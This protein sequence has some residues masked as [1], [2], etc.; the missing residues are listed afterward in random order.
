[1]LQNPGESETPPGRAPAWRAS[2]LGGLA[3]LAAAWLVT[4][5][6]V[7]EASATFE[8]GPNDHCCLSGFADHYEVEDG[9]GTRWTSYDATLDLPLVVE[10]GPVE[11]EL[12]GARVFPQTA[13]VELELAGATVDRGLVEGGVLEA[14]R[15]VA[16]GDVEAHPDPRAAGMAGD[17]GRE[18]VW[19][20]PSATGRYSI[21]AENRRKDC[22]HC[23][24]GWRSGRHCN[25]S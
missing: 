24:S 25:R 15:R 11:L 1:M 17:A 23:F 12:R 2:L 10:G 16:A 8:L 5:L 13:Q 6:P 4:G 14:L 7:R 20:D 19:I 18:F 22:Q 9:V 21:A 3:V